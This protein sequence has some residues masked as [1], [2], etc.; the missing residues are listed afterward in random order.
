VSVDS[1]PLAEAPPLTGPGPELAAARRPRALRLPRSPKVIAGLVIL[2]LYTV[3]AL[4]GQWIAPYSPNATNGQQWV[5]RVL[6]DGTGPGTNVPA[7]YYPLP[8]PPSAAHWLGT[9]VFAQD[10]MSQL[11]ASTQATLFVGLLAAVIAT[12]LSIAAGVAAGY[13]GG[14]TDEGL[15]LVANVFLAIPGLPLLIV[16]A[17]YVPSAGS[18]V[19]LVSVIIAVTAWAYTA[20]V[21]RAQTLSVRN[22]D[23]IE[24]ARVSGERSLRIIGVEVLPNLVPIIAASFLFTTL[25]A[26]Y[27]Y[28]AIAFLGLAGSPTSSP[29]GLWNWGE[30]LRQGFA[31]NAIRGGWWWWWA[32]PG[33]LVALLGTGLALLNFGIDEFINPRLRAAGLSRRAAR[34]ARVSIRQTFGLTPVVRREPGSAG[35]DTAIGPRSLHATPRA[36]SVASTVARQAQPQPGPVLEIRGL[37]VDYGYGDEAVHAV[38]NCDL[39]LRRGQVLGL[40]GESGSGKSTLAMA[41][42]R[43]LRQPGVITAGEVLFHSR[44]VSG[45]GHGGTVDILAAGEEELRS[46]RWSEISVVLQ[47]ALNS[48]NP[49]ATIGAQFDDLLQTHRPGLSRAERRER[50]AE[51]LGMVSMSGDRLG[52]YPHELS[53]GMRQRAMIALAL[54]L[55]PQVMILDEP[56]T[57]LDVVT[58]REILEE[59]MGLRDRLGFA[60]LYIT[61]D[62]SLLVEFADE[63]A[64][65]YAGRL[66]ERAP[67][68]SLFHAPRLPYT[69]GLLNCFPPMHGK[70]VAMEGIPGSPPDLRHLPAGCAFHPRCAWAIQRCHQE[71]PTLLPLDGHGREVACWLHQGEAIVPA[72]LDFPDPKSLPRAGGGVPGAIGG[73]GR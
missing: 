8:L 41:A 25:Y 68:A 61:H 36:I 64:V 12:I 23:F 2:A 51:L 52:S 40:A 3:V 27:A 18:S 1:T 32:P 70:R 30:M 28:V 33:V 56:T 5:R 59:L 17:D 65:M 69:H 24:A 46:L 10:A 34:K 4:I 14:G 39:V 9:T 71:M 66:M 50:A 38:V 6:V 63:I 73:G 53:G 72:E 31:N 7:H 13:F 48:L 55:E 54:A 11:L 22:R 16:L 42:I 37:S 57:A 47:S 43:L 20:R 15:S 44:P 45:N 58:Q 60:A 67:A 21:L 26:T 62:L 19:V 49:V 35:P 29:P